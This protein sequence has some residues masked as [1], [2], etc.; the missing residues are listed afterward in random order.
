MDI[1]EVYLEKEKEDVDKENCI[2]CLKCIEACPEDKA[3]SATFMKKNIFSSSKAYF[4]KWIK[5]E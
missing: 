5:E 2:F 1:E 3:L 4:T